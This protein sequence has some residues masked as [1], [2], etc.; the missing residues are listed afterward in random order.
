MTLGQEL[1]EGVALAVEVKV[2]GA[3]RQARLSRDVFDLGA[4]QALLGKDALGRLEQAAFGMG[5]AR[6]RHSDLKVTDL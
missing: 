2:E 6:S 4:I 1:F 5:I 3:L